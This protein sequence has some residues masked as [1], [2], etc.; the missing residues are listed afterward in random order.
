M[1]IDLNARRSAEAAKGKEPRMLRVGEREFTLTTEMSLGVVHALGEGDLVGAARA[2]LK[3]PEADFDEFVKLVTIDD[4]GYIV[5]N[6]GATMGESSGSTTP[7]QDTGEPSTPTS[8]DITEP[9]LE[10]AVSDSV[11]GQ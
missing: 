8:P 6:W 4:I 2:I 11:P 3:D 10:T 5:T 1:L 9:I 7:F